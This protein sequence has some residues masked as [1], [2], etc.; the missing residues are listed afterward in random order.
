MKS[1]SDVVR[2]FANDLAIQIS[3]DTTTVL[4]ESKEFL[5]S[6]EDAELINTW[7]EICVQ[8][9]HELSVVW[10]YYDEVTRSIILPKVQ[11]LKEYEKLAL[12]FQSNDGIDWLCDDEDFREE[13]PMFL[14]SEIVQYIA[15]GFVYSSAANWE[16]ERIQAYL[17]RQYLD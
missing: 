10:D 3:D 16:N 8:I 9:Q 6:G 11:K 4:Q 17:D 5:L 14:D 2:E 1:E 15:D 12:W 13:T 7:D